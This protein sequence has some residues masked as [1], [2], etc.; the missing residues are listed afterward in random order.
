MHMCDLTHSQTRDSII[1]DTTRS[2]VPMT[3]SYLTLRISC[4]VVCVRVCVCVRACV[5]VC[6]CV[7]AYE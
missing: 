6:V 2:C 3:H 4:D 5:Y 1:F 7:R